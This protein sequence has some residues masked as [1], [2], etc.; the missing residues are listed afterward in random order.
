MISKHKSVDL[1][2]TPSLIVDLDLME[3]NSK[4][5]MNFLKGK[6]CFLRPH[7]KAHKIPE[8]AKFQISQGAK[9]IC[10]AK[11]GEAEVMLENGLDDIL[12][13]TPIAN[14]QKID[15][16]IK[17]LKTYPK[18][19]IIQV[20][21]GVKQVNALAEKLK[22]EKLNLE[23]LVEVEAG[24]KRCGVQVGTELI[25]LVKA[26]RST[27][28][29]K[30]VGY[31]AY[32]GHLQHIHGYEKRK[33]LARQA[34]MPLV[35]LLAKEND[36]DLKYEILSGGGTG[37]YDVYE[38]LPFTE[39]QAG[40][41]IF[42]DADYNN[43]GSKDGNNKYTDF[44]CALKVISTVISMPTSTRAIVDA[45][46]KCLSIDSGM[47]ILENHPEIS[48]RSGGDEHGILDLPEGF[49][50]FDIGQKL[51]FIP[52]HCDTT[53]NQFDKLYGVRK[54]IIE[55]EWNIKARGRSN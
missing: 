13:T 11:L 55:T 42:M 50:K 37:T 35:G 20:V 33:E 8:L 52:S 53:L 47:P 25:K 14:E 15:R 36:P 1:L 27:K 5:M 51:I 3:N 40:S 54:N 26:I 23:V 31:Q 45:G 43:I 7:A 12:I 30:F 22:K 44:Q 19:R 10:T 46:M 49:S 18:A 28:N 41:Y 4:K 16:M 6:K 39:L 21:D 2:D 17:A 29:L 24:Q 32:S 48:Y 38:D 9:G 34:V